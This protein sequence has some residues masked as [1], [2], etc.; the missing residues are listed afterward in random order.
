MGD[1][2]TGPGARGTPALTPD[3]S[4]ED[5]DDGDADDMTLVAENDGWWVVGRMSVKFP[6]SKHALNA[7]QR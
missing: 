3:V 2:Q 6:R 4:F 7:S 5:G 1:A